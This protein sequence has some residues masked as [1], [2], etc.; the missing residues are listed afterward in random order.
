MAG[1]KKPRPAVDRGCGEVMVPVIP[2][3]T[4]AVKQANGTKVG[5]SPKLHY[6]R[7][8]RLHI[9]PKNFFIFTLGGPDGIDNQDITTICVMRIFL[10]NGLIYL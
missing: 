7:H 2:P 9:R 3:K 5:L 1:K 4:E 10:K 6:I 8:L